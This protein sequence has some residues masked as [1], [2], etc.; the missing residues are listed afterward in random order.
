MSQNGVVSRGSEESLAVSIYSDMPPSLI[1][2]DAND[3]YHY[4][5]FLMKN[6]IKTI[7]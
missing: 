6:P 7:K 1:G 3:C 5:F 2:D 4:L